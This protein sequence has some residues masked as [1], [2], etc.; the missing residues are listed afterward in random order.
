LVRPEP[1]ASAEREKL[2]YFV[3]VRQFETSSEIVR[4]AYGRLADATAATTSWNPRTVMLDWLETELN[5]LRQ[6]GRR[7]ATAARNS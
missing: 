2:F 1:R 3:M 6:M 5:A 7:P 4:A